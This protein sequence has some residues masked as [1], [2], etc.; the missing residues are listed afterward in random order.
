MKKRQPLCRKP[1]EVLVIVLQDYH[2]T[3]SNVFQCDTQVA[4]CAKAKFLDA[5]PY[6]PQRWEIL[7]VTHTQTH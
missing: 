6:I 7:M 4:F 1:R 3:V 5:T 2:I